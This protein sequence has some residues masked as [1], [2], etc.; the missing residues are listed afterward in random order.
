MK[1]EIGCPQI[2]WVVAFKKEAASIIELFSLRQESNNGSGFP[3]WRSRRNTDGIIHWLVISGL[4]KVNAA[5]A[6]AWL[7]K[8]A[9]EPQCAAWVNFGIAGH[10]DLAL[11]R[12]VW[13]SKVTDD[14]SKKS[15]YPASTWKRG[16]K[17]QRMPLRT[18]DH[19]SSDYPEDGSMVDMESSGF[20][21]TAT[22]F[23]TSE[24]VQSIKVV[25]DNAA[26]DFQK[27]KMH[28]VQEN[29]RSAI[30]KLTPWIEELSRLIDIERR[31]TKVPNE[32]AELVKR[33][34]FTQ[35][36]LFQLKR[37]LSRRKA[38]AKR[39]RYRELVKFTSSRQVISAL[40]ETID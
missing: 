9:G 29:C 35:T 27:I 24:L 23:C 4:G 38:L 12:V 21:A 16:I 10:K 15:W 5:A 28:D 1:E 25:S 6:T 30:G 20:F 17:L 37:I 8:E 36:Q 26:S 18:L 11:G 19:P 2:H 34:N 31:R 13:V 3:V 33:F 39:L 22:R 40:R 32:Y 7:Q 14:S